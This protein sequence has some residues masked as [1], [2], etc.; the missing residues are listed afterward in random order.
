MSELD[1]QRGTVADLAERVRQRELSAREVTAHAIARLE[2]LDPQVNAFVA[3]DGERALAE[4]AA[5]DERSARGEDV[6]PLAGVPIGVKDLED[7]AGF[8]TTYGCKLNVADPPAESDSPLVARLRRAGCVVL[9]KTNTPEF[10]HKGV[11]DNPA[12][13]ATANPWSLEHSAGGSSGGTGAAIA[14]GIVPLGTGSDGGG[15]IRIPAAVCGQTGIKCSQGRV[16]LGGPHPPGSGIL[17]VKGPMARTIRDVVLALGAVVGPVATDVF[18]LDAP[19]LSWVDAVDLSAAPPVRVAWCPTLGYGEVDSEVLA[20]CQGAVDRLAELGTEVVDLGAVWTEP[21]LD[22]WLTMW[23]VQRA[24]VHAHLR[25]TP[26]WGELGE[27]LRAQVEAGAEIDGVTYARAIDAAH[28]L[29]V[30]FER[31]VAEVGASLVLCPTL[32]GFVPRLDAGTEGTIDGVT[33][34]NW[35]QYTFP[36]NLTRNPAGTV[37]AGLSRA[38]LPVGLQVVGR[39]R[40]DLGVLGALVALEDAIGFAAVPPLS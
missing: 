39:Q 9:G 16:P 38:G 6:G 27:S 31:A 29:N 5:L 40:D 37:C 8:R 28:L 20:V 1:F 2:A 36:F 12:F 35:V 4:A 25:G 17:S 15:S 24:K 14:A 11:T 18:S 21:P 22:P 34:S 26:A 10:G 32:A 3:W 23:L 7:A 30:Q 33:T 13:G 19:A